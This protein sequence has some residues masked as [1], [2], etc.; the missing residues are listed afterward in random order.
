MRRLGGL[1]AI[2]IAA[3]AAGCGSDSEDTGTPTS[4]SPGRTPVTTRTAPATAQP[5]DT[6]APAI[7]ATAVAPEATIAPHPTQPPRPTAPPTA[8][9]PPTIPPSGVSR[10]IA[11]INTTFV[12][13]SITAPRG[14]AITITLDNQDAGVLHDLVIFDASGARVAETEIFAGPDSRTVTFTPAGPGTY[15]FT[16]TVHPRE[17]RGTLTVQ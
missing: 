7:T 14:A 15:P 6:Q 16:C 10:T 9:P 5:T 12:P 17:M 3:A 8:P 2:I 13:S 4:V 1:V 11:V